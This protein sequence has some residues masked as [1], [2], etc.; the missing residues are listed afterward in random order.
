M[1]STVSAGVARSEK[2]APP[3]RLEDAPCTGP[4]WVTLSDMC[5]GVTLV[6]NGHTYMDLKRAREQFGSACTF[7]PSNPF[8]VQA[9]LCFEC[10][11]IVLAV[12]TPATKNRD[13]MF[14]T[15]DNINAAFN[16]RLVSAKPRSK[17]RTSIHFGVLHPWFQSY[18][19]R[20]GWPA[21]RVQDVC[22]LPQMGFSA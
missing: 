16:G 2:R 7:H 3:P 15:L 20:L 4:V 18:L 14:T 1:G 19:K 5:S 6:Y 8:Y 10:G 12:I 13:A 21:E 11:T 22:T 17:G 9:L